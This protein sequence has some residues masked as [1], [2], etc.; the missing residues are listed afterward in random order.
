[1]HYDDPPPDEW[2]DLDSVLGAE[3][4]RFANDLGPGSR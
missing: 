4:A 3:G 1:M 2:A